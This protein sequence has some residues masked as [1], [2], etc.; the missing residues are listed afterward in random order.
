MSFFCVFLFVLVRVVALSLFSLAPFFILAINES[1]DDLCTMFVMM[2]G[3]GG[4]LLLLSL[5]LLLL[6]LGLFFVVSCVH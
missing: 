6:G 2:N 4:S 3:L 5:L 1:Q